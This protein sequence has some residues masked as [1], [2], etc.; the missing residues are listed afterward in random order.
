MVGIILLISLFLIYHFFLAPKL[1]SPGLSAKT[2]VIKGVSYQ[3]E[4][5]TTNQQ[6]SL[7]L[8]GRTKLC[9]DCGMLFVFAIPGS[10]PFWMKDT[11]IPLDMIW[12]TSSGTVVSI[13]TA[14][15]QPNDPVYKLKLYRNVTPAQY[16]IE[17]NAGDA[18]ILG[19]KIGDTIDLAIDN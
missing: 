4:V 11:L 10:L 6:L 1:Q 5:A 15:P 8:S 3:L 7:G 9:P 14:E 18:Q 19:L 12:L 13:Q 16:V 2:V 17:L